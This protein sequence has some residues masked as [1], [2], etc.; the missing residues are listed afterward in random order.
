MSAERQGGSCPARAFLVDL[1]AGGRIVAPSLG[2]A[3]APWAKLAPL[4]QIGHWPRLLISVQAL[5]RDAHSPEDGAL[6]RGLEAFALQKVVSGPCDK[7]IT[8]GNVLRATVV[9]AQEL[10]HFWLDSGSLLGPLRDGSPI[11]WDSDIDFGAWDDQLPRMEALAERLRPMGVKVTSRVYRGRIFGYTIKLARMKTVHL[12]IN[13]RQGAT[14][15]RPQ[16]ISYYRKTRPEMARYFPG[17][18]RMRRLMQLTYQVHKHKH[19]RHPIARKVLSLVWRVFVRIRSGYPREDWTRLYPFRLLHKTATWV[20]PAH[21][22]EQLAQLT[23]DHVNVPIPH[24]V[25]TYLAIRY[26]ADWDQPQPEWLYWLDDGG[27]QLS[28]PEE[29]GYGKA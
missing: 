10:T 28:E 12:H 16:T 3:R 29:L 14:L 11:S 13:Y 7:A 26:G 18:K 2:G 17:H 8:H 23:L 19:S 5:R 9:L 24:D 25:L 20:L 1:A 4:A 21:H 27:L 6:L 15:W 22:F